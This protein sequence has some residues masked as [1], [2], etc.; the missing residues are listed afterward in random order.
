MLI[1]I[2][3]RTVSKLSQTIVQILDEKQSLCVFEPT[4]GGLVAKYAVHLRLITTLEV[5]FL[6]V[7]TELFFA[8]GVTA[9]ALRANMD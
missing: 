1:D 8:I 2:L 9:E 5:D 6:F 3:C 7:L 4:F